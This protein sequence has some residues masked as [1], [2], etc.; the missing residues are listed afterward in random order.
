[1]PYLIAQA[2][3]SPLICDAVS[4]ALAWVDAAR[5]IQAF[6]RGAGGV[7][8][9]V[10]LAG[11]TLTVGAVRA[12]AADEAHSA[13]VGGGAHPGGLAVDSPSSG[14]GHSGRLA[15]AAGPGST[16]PAGSA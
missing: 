16:P 11:S 1:L 7:R 12:P 3:D 5:V 2:L 4:I 8:W 9:R 13:P 14:A 15:S 6:A 10:A